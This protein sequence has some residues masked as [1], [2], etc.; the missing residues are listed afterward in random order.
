[1]ITKNSNK[2]IILIVDFHGECDAVFR[3]IDK[4]GL[5]DC[6]L[7]GVGDLGIG[8]KSERKQTREIELLNNR[9]K[10]KN[11]LFKGIRGNHDDPAY[12]DGKI[13]ESHFELLPDYA[14]RI[15]NGKSF[16]FVGGAVSIDRRVRVPTVSWW[17]DEI[18]V[19][20]T[21]LV[22][23]CDVLITH[24]APNWNGHFAK[25][26]IQSWC[27]KDPTLWE[28]CVKEREDMAKLIEICG[29]KQHYCGHFHCSSFA[30]VNGCNSRI[31]NILELYE[32][33]S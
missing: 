9:F 21:E 28:E 3:E 16:L 30:F 19:L 1:M 12:F 32:V 26:G 17:E 6:L 24:T 14:Y 4:F 18:F 27:D 11:I 23:P 13:N 5:K 10:S 29:A 2:P 8:F 7:I 15:I 22:K 33:L 25:Q 31:L 20:N